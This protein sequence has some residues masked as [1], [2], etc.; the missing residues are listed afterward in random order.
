MVY[1][2]VQLLAMPETK[3]EIRAC[4]DPTR[5][6]HRPAKRACDSTGCVAEKATPDEPESPFCCFK[7]NHPQN[8][9]TNTTLSKKLCLKLHLVLTLEAFAENKNSRALQ[10]II[11]VKSRNAIEM[12]QKLEVLTNQ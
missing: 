10:D 2:D 1:L 11:Q 8:K 5:R 6:V 12:W 7:R 9:N 3:K 4:R